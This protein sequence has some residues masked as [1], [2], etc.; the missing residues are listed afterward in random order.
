MALPAYHA[1]TGCNYMACF[2]RK[3]KIFPLKL[4]EKDVEAQ[5]TIGRLYSEEP[6]SENTISLIERYVSKIYGRPKVEIVDQARFDIFVEKYRPKGNEESLSC[7]KK[8]DGSSLP[9]CSK[10]LL[11]KIKRTKFITAMW[12][13]SNQPHPPQQNPE[14]SGWL[15]RNGKYQIL[16]YQEE[17]SPKLVDV[18]CN[19]F[20]E[21]EEE[22]GS[23]E[24]YN[25]FYIYT[26]FKINICRLLDVV[27]GQNMIKSDMA[28]HNLWCEF[29]SKRK[30]FDELNFY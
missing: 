28:Y 5:E 8:L 7:V 29:L 1:L 10:T 15:L 24:F 13:S 19:D 12:M 26:R 14:S 25:L 16:W 21:Y 2:R 3:G 22:E 6:I 18:A 11:E 4:L 9:P 23:V 17:A 27:S 30:S 20:D